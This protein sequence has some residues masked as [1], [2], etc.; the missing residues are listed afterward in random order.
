MI[1]PHR[2][3][4]AIGIGGEERLMRLTLGELAA[5]EA[6]LEV[7]GLVALAE[8]FE[9]GAFRANDLIALLTAGLRG[10]GDDLDEAEVAAMDFD[11]GAIGAAEAASRLLA[12]S[13]RGTT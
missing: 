9:T 2:G 7:G 10:G 12:A 11:G 13:F 5:L 8:R 6:R 3:E 1:N 4:V